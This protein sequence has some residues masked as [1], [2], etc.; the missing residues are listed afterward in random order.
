[1]KEKPIVLGVDI[2]GSHIT[3]ALIDLER[4]EIVPG[5][6]QRRFVDA[7]EDAEKILNEWCMV[8]NQSF[9][10]TPKANR[11]IGIAMPGPFD[12]E[13]G[14]SKIKDQEKF[15]S[16]YNLNVRQE[17]AQ[18]LNI[19]PDDI[20]F[21]ND[22]ASFLQGEVYC[23]AARDYKKVLGLTLG[24]GLG[25]AICDEGVAKDADLWNS[26]FKEG[27]VEDYLSSRWFLKRY[28]ELAGDT[29]SDVKELTELRRSRNYLNQIFSDFSTNLVTFITPLIK[30]H[31]CDAVVIGG[32]ISNAYELFLPEV[33][34]LL[35]EARID[36]PIKIADL[37][38][39]ASLIGAA[40]C[41]NH[42]D[43]RS[44]AQPVKQN[45]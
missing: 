42:L 43:I 29:V 31:G 30:K 8:I 11:K 3:A 10:T 4:R 19:R 14:I 36:V 32:N 25:S 7:Q 44:Q 13:L 40:S 17:L 35:A 34:K 15:Q 21:I 27:I 16:L 20:R 23:G 6:L 38:E 33:D 5:S 41:W 37:K 24:T 22:A 12:Y 18:R 2:G 45:T 26:A 9:D 1:M 28:T 39:D